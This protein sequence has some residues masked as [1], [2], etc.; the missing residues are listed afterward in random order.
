VTKHEAKAMTEVEIWRAAQKMIELYDLEAASVAGLRVDE[1]F[2]QGDIDGMHAWVKVLAAI[3]ELQPVVPD[4][5][6]TRH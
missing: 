5:S 6:S 1:F 4:R 3:K 2:G